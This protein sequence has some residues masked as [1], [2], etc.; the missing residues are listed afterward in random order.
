M[1]F[2]AD[3]SFLFSLHIPDRNSP[4]AVAALT[5]LDAP[6]IFSALQEFELWNAFRLAV[7]R[8]KI[9]RTEY[10]RA[11]HDALLDVTAGVLVRTS[12]SWSELFSE[13][14]TLSSAHTEALGNRGMDILHV[15]AA[16]TLGA[17]T[18]LSFD[19]RQRELAQRAGLKIRP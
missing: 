8:K 9:T 15:A 13:A 4:V 3:T 2:Y 19:A 14:E 6:L 18:F 10:T 7:F 16:R 11:L 17:K 1:S 5:R 12:L